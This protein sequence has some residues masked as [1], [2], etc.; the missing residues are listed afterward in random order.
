M[1]IHIALSLPRDAATVAVARHLCGLA[2]EEMGATEES[3]AD[4]QLVLS[5]A[6]ANVLE[7]A[8]NGTEYDVEVDIDSEGCRVRVIDTGSG[9]EVD[10]SGDA[11]A[12]L[13]EGGR[14]IPLMRALVDRLDFATDPDVGT[15]VNLETAVAYT[16]DA[17]AR[18]T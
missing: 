2:L 6:C 7:H 10:G 9:F 5:E 13:R 1:R 11:S 17:L 15:I 18:R 12:G 8:A 4:V 3:R 16:D 14:G